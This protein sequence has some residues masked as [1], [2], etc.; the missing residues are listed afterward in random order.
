MYNRII[1]IY[2]NQKLA[3]KIYSGYNIFWIFKKNFNWIDFLFYNF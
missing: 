2:Y 1:N 3:T